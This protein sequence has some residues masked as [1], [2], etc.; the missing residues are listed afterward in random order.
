MLRNSTWR[1]R[2]FEGVN[3][4]PLWTQWYG[5]NLGGGG[6]NILTGDG[7]G[8]KASNSLE[9]YNLHK[10]HVW[11]F[12][13]LESS[14]KITYSDTKVNQVKGASWTKRR[15][16]EKWDT[17]N[18][19]FPSVSGRDCDEWYLLLKSNGTICAMYRRWLKGVVPCHQDKICYGYRRTKEDPDFFARICKFLCQCHRFL[20]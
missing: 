1:T 3:Y 15:A 6:G 5:N 4:D 18:G 13:T 7:A 16:K 17:Q 14:E 10:L 8:K 12:G 20:K 11:F 9:P 2:R 19:F